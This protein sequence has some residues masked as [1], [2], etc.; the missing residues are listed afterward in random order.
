M[1]ETDALQR[2]LAGEHAAIYGYGVAGA[3][4]RGRAR[5]DATT[6]YD[7]HL[8]R[9]TMLLAKIADA[10]V[11]PAPAAAA[12][13]LPFRVR[14]AKE[15]QN[16]AVTLEEGIAS[17]YADVV[18]ETQGEVREMAALALQEA[19]VRAA[20]WRGRSVAFPG[21]RERVAAGSP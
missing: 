3:R 15:A 7:D 16:L 8:A 10:G 18:A 4:M 13:D 6:A 1:S 21:L 14:T 17:T 20:R 12:Y 2:A 9:R 5:A 19:A 11:A